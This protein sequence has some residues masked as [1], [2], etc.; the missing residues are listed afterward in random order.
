ME[1]QD[2]QKIEVDLQGTIDAQEG[3]DGDARGAGQRGQ[4]GEDGE[5]VRGRGSWVEGGGLVNLVVGGWRQGTACCR[6]ISWPGRESRI[7]GLG[8]LGLGTCHGPWG[9]SK[10]GF[11]G[12]AGGPLGLPGSRTW[13][14]WAWLTQQNS[15]LHQQTSSGSKTPTLQTRRRWQLA[16]RGTRV[17]T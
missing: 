13:L 11:W 15:G 14:G 4:R 10:L 2:L 12:S 6:K 3:Y 5:G 16:T 9:A 7:G 8:A 1:T 17:G